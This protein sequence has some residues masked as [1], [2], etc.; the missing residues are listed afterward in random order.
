MYEYVEKFKELYQRISRFEKMVNEGNFID[1][2]YVIW[3]I[4]TFRERG[5]KVMDKK[6][7]EIYQF[8]LSETDYLKEA[9]KNIEKV[10]EDFLQKDS[11]YLNG[12]EYEEVRDELFA[13]TGF[14]EETGFIKGFQYAVLLMAEC[15]TAKQLL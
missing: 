1:Y 10:V 2:L 9:G 14:A 6:T 5:R 13:V 8:L 4:G 15:Y 7:K 12:K 3:N 11:L